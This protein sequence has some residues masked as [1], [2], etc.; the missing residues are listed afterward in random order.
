MREPAFSEAAFIATILADCSL[1]RFSSTALYTC[2]W[3]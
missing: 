1:A 2:D 3:I